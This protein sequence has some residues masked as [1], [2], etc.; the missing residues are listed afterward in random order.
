MGYSKPSSV[1]LKDAKYSNYATITEDGTNAKS[2]NNGAFNLGLGFG[3]H[4]TNAIRAE[5]Q[6]KASGGA[7]SS[8]NKEITSNVYAKGK[9]SHS[10]VGFLLNGFYDHKFTNEFSAFV[11]AGLGFAVVSTKY[12]MKL[13]LPS[14]ST[15]LGSTASRA[16]FAYAL[17][18]G[19]AYDLTNNFTTE[20]SYSYR[21][22]GKYK[23]LDR[24]YKSTK[25]KANF[26]GVAS[27]HNI[28]LGF[29][30]AF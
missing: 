15:E 19:L 3:Y 20:L 24:E 7:E 22:N 2:S 1:K 10:S 12:N 28:N 23:S 30:Y 26:K 4:I 9:F 17:H 25:F 8:F 29:R 13:K 14:T 11:G 6:I 21:N 27:S 16:S 5:L 18:A